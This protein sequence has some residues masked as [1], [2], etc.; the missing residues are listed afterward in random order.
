M[1]AG[2]EFSS[3]LLLEELQHARVENLRNVF[4]RRIGILLHQEVF[5]VGQSGSM[6][7]QVANCDGS[8]IGREL[9][10]KVGKVVVIVKFAVASQ[11]HDGGSGELLG[12]RCQPE[13]RLPLN[14]AHG[15]QVRAAISA[16]ENGLSFANDED[17]GPGGARGLQGGEDGVDLGWGN[18][19]GGGGNGKDQRT[20]KYGCEF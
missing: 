6:V 14:G 17:C 11:Q 19:G 8:S 2:S 5:V 20:R 9:G 7:E 15:A 10:K 4:L 13:I 1:R 18:L 16:A 12:E 3:G